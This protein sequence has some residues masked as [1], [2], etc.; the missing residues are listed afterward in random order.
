MRNQIDHACINRRWR[1][2]LF[3]A[4]TQRGADVASDHELVIS[5]IKVKLQ[6]IKKSRK[7]GFRRDKFNTEKLKQRETLETFKLELRNRYQALTENKD[8]E[9]LSI[10][11]HW[12]DIKDFFIKTG[13][14]VLGPKRDN[15]EAWISVR[16]WELIN[17]RKE[18]KTKPILMRNRD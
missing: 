13:K 1:R 6:K 12:I 11:D 3:D 7:S 17:E 16:S 2:S 14:E 5:K 8:T 15:K 18:L 4:R 9:E 10:E